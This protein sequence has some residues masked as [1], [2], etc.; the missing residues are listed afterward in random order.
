MGEAV[1]K[2]IVDTVSRLPDDGQSKV[3]AYAKALTLTPAAKKPLK[4]WRHIIGTLSHEDA[5]ALQ[6]VI[7]AGCRQVDLREW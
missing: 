6:R 1:L 4:D 2:E 3:L 5:E 7:D